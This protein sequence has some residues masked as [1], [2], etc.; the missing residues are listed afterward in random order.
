MGDATIQGNRCMVTNLAQCLLQGTKYEEVL[1]A[2]IFNKNSFQLS[3]RRC[4]QG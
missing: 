2:I 1:S 3:L 4:L